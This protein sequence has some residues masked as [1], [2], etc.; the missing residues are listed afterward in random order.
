MNELTLNG[1]VSK[2]TNALPQMFEQENRF[3]V[4]RGRLVLIVVISVAARG[5]LVQHSGIT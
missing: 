3:F 4:G 5:Y 1:N 2:D